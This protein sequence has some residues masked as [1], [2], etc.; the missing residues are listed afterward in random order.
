[1][2]QEGDVLSPS[3][4]V[5]ANPASSSAIT[6]IVTYNHNQSQNTISYEN[7]S[8]LITPNEMASPTFSS[9][10]SIVFETL[11]FSYN[12]RE[13]IPHHSSL[14][15]LPV[16]P[17][18]P[19]I[20]ESSFDSTLSEFPLLD[21]DELLMNSIRNLNFSPSS[22]ENE[23]GSN[24][25]NSNTDVCD[26]RKLKCIYKKNRWERERRWSARRFEGRWVF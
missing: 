19:K 17:N 3:F 8:D 20:S 9:H 7:L 24:A 4:T 5:K 23:E 14:Q 10:S 1:M 12:S 2:T 13:N 6:D 21:C 15:Y 25:L 26:A 18:S 22:S 11:F 16:P